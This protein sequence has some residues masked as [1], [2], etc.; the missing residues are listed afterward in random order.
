MGGALKDNGMVG[1]SAYLT[2]AEA[3]SIRLYIQQQARMK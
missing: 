1:F 2:A 3:E